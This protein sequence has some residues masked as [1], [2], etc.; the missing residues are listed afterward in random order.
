MPRNST[1]A[2]EI[3]AGATPQSVVTDSATETKTAAVTLCVSG[4]G[5]KVG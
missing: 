4:K 2:V 3:H 1:L 5:E